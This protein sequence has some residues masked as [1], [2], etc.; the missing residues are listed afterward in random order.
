MEEA[1][2]DEAAWNS[3]V[4]ETRK[5]DPVACGDLRSDHRDAQFHRSDVLG[6]RNSQHAISCIHH[7][8]LDRSWD[9][10]LPEFTLCE[11]LPI[12]NNLISPGESVTQEQ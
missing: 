3:A 7:G 6:R 1:Y 10:L 9:R 8:L 12:K 11:K 4:R 2:R 5:R